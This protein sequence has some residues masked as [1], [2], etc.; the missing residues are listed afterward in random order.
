MNPTRIIMPGGRSWTPGASYDRTRRE[1]QSQKDREA[2]LDRQRR[3]TNHLTPRQSWVPQLVVA[4][5]FHDFIF[6]ITNKYFCFLQIHICRKGI[7][8][9]ILLSVTESIV[10]FSWAFLWNMEQQVVTFFLKLT[11]TRSSVIF[12]TY[13]CAVTTMS[14]FIFFIF[15]F[16]VL[17]FVA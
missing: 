10:C 11:W 8:K 5:I 17:Y 15:Y 14:F 4:Y 1:Q 16:V 13:L 3:W 9:Y 7:K 2:R 6:Q 12:L